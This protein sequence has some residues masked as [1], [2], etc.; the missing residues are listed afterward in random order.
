MPK[1]ETWFDVLGNPHRRNILKLLYKKELYQD[2]LAKKIGIT[3]I[4]VNKHLEILKNR[5]IIFI[6]EKERQDGRGGRKLKYCYFNPKF[7]FPHNFGSPFSIK[8]DRSRS[9]SH[10]EEEYIDVE[11][12]DV[13]KSKIDLD[14]IQL[15][16]SEK[17]EF[18]KYIKEFQVSQQDIQLYQPKL[19]K[20]QN[21]WDTS[22]QKIIELIKQEDIIQVYSYLFENF[23]TTKLFT[24]QDVMSARF[25]CS[26]DTAKLIIDILERDLEL[27]E[28]VEMDQEER[29]PKWRLLNFTNKETAVS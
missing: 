10:E 12:K 3:P 15:T 4:A 20:A 24:R 6:K 25:N 26:Y 8:F 9:K 1:V 13:S 27:A 11:I 16:D 7:K 19:M 21:R 5:G 23:S 29:D 18:I 17:F 2:E 14:E 22:S 28:Y